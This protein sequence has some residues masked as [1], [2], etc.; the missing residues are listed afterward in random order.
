MAIVVDQ[1]RT[2]AAGDRQQGQGVGVLAHLRARVPQ[3]G[4]IALPPLIGQ[5]EG[6]WVC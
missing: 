6:G 2:F 4:Q 5:R 1:P 3:H